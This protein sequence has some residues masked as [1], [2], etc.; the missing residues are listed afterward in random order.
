MANV[1]CLEVYSESPDC[2]AVFQPTNQK[3]FTARIQGSNSIR[4][5]VVLSNRI[6]ENVFNEME[7]S[8]KTRLD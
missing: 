3:V 5:K 7:K 1:I 8:T 2:K 4:I 6:F